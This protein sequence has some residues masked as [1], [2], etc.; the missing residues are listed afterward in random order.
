MSVLQGRVYHIETD[1][2]FVIGQVVSPGV[3]FQGTRYWAIYSRGIIHLIDP[4]DVIMVKEVK[5]YA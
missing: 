5:G 4:D 2:A 3:R 1:E